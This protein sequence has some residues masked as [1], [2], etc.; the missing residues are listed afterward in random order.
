[1]DRQRVKVAKDRQVNTYAEMW[2]ASHVMLNKAEKDEKGSYYQL[3]ASLIFIAFTLEAYL[4]HI[5]KRIFGCW[6][7]LEQL[8]PQKKLNV[9]AE[10]LKVEKDDGK[11]PFQTVKELFKLR[12]DIAHGK[13][14]FLKSE[15]QI[16]ATDAELDN[17]MH[18]LLETEWEKYCNIENTQRA[19]EDVKSIIQKLHN[20]SGLSEYVF[21]LGIGGGLASVIPEK[22]N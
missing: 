7:D 2:H 10:K 17:Y 5:G 19:R 9:I 6:D 3:M 15:N 11:R 14:V 12:N 4:N 20:A 21:D 18:R 8:S 1:M 13:S 16:S 22:E